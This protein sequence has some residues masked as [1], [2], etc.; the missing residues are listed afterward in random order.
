MASHGEDC[1]AIGVTDL[2]RHASP[3]PGT[4]ATLRQAPHSRKSPIQAP[5][6]DHLREAAQVVG[7]VPS[8]AESAGLLFQ[9]MGVSASASTRPSVDIITGVS[10]P[11]DGGSSS[12]SRGYWSGASVRT[13]PHHPDGLPGLAGRQGWRLRH[14]DAMN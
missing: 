1:P 14:F 7:S 5:R 12:R 11:R 13:H 6:K 3:P 2:A 9:V 10:K 4:P 8:R